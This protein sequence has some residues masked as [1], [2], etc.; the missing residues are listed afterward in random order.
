[1]KYTLPHNHGLSSLVVDKLVF[2]DD[3]QPALSDVQFEALEAGIGRGE[4]ALVVSPTSTGKTQIALW[5]ITHSLQKG[6]CTVYL[7]THRALAKQK[8]DDFRSKLVT[9]FM[10]GDA[11][12]LVIATGDY[13]E[14]ADGNAPKEPLRTPLLVATYEKYLAMLSASGIPQDMKTTTIVCDEIQLIGDKSRG[15]QVEVLL[16]LLR[17]AGWKQFVGLSAVLEAKDAK[18]LADW[19]GVKLILQH[20]R[21]KHLQY[22][23]WTATG[24]AVASSE[25]PDTIK[26]GLPVPAN[27]NL[28][29]VAALASLL[30]EKIPPV[31]IIVFCMSKRE[32]Y[33]LP[34][35]FLSKYK[36]PKGQLLLP[37]EELP[38]TTA[39]VFL[40]ESMSHRVAFHNADL[41]DE[42]RHI[43]EQ[44][45]LEGKLDVVFAT[46]TL[47]AGVNFPLGAAI[48]A[49]WQRPD[50]AKR[51]SVPIESSDFH[52]MAG[53]VGRMGTAR[54]HG[55]VIFFAKASEVKEARKY[56]DLG[57]L[58]SLESRVTTQ[59]F[60]Q[61]ALQLV[62]SGLCNSRGDVETLVCTT[63][64]ALREE[65][66]NT[67]AFALWPK[68]LSDAIDGLV[69][70]NLLIQTTS[71]HL[72]ATPVGKAVSQSGLLPET[73]IF[74]LKYAIDKAERLA[75]CLPAATKHGD[76]DR[77]AF[78]FFSACFS[79][80]EFQGH[81]GKP[82]T[83]F[84]PYPLKE[85][86]LFDANV[87]RE[88][89]IEPI[90]QADIMPINAAKLCCDYMNG[91][92]IRKLESLLPRL[93]AGNIRDMCRDLTWVLQGL[94]AVIAAAADGR[95]PEE[96]RPTVMHGGEAKLHLL[97]KLPRVMYRLSYRVTE[98]LPDD[99]L[100]MA[101]ICDPGSPYRLRRHE[102]LIL[103]EHGFISPQ[104]VM[105]G[106]NEADAI[107]VI[108][109]ENAKPA[110]IVKANWLRDA[111][112]NWKINERKRA[113]ERHI[114]RAQRCH[115]E[116][117][118]EKYYSSI[119][120]DFEKAFE[121]ILTALKIQYDRLD[122]STRTGAPDYL[123]KLRNSPELVVELKSKEKDNL[124]D[125]NGATD[126]L[127]ASEI[128]GHKDKFCVTLCHRGV[129]PS[130][131]MVIV[132]C[133][134]LSVVESTDLGEALLRACEGILLQ[135]QLYQWL[136]SPGQ[137]LAGDL[138]YREYN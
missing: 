62:G 88:D 91:D 82:Q 11:S 64:S 57:A 14:D 8:F 80:P 6:G 24:M 137:A 1:L 30:K 106:S 130:V 38:E 60:N 73:G 98:G 103:R 120:T 22:E 35:E 110:S 87:Y 114:K 123:I 31:P 79:S 84:L 32:T 19:L 9:H 54:E 76:I 68:K 44:H 34:K 108:A 59:R 43:V 41:M 58:P 27:V 20:T 28:D 25:F 42:E 23:C 127:R 7:V 29:P 71:G 67:A 85:E 138:P 10:N 3:G 109:F 134:R 81:Y 33:D 124:V 47:A 105:L 53:R 95:I 97:K 63:L 48:F 21:E 86:S 5:A 125:L 136:A 77:L 100:W 117:L 93:R 128:H 96:L 46:T 36:V 39:N 115:S 121:G 12:G 111:C 107:R 18:D 135:E 119:G 129:D 51:C 74:L 4:S 133:G 99:V 101:S 113:A 40:S 75:S 83:R 61:L 17:N 118:F 72:S 69:E 16:T 112:R 94:A 2:K 65:V 13:V 132:D 49:S 131:P 15:Q 55:R 122:D 50:F 66:Q 92:E 26:E 126:V 56:L 37:F 52:N 116:Q 70:Q 89:L 45:L 102:I 104:Q 78:L 90:W